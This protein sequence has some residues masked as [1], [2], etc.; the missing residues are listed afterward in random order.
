MRLGYFSSKSREPQRHS[1]I[2]LK[3]L[4]LPFGFGP[5]GQAE[6]RHSIQGPPSDPWNPCHA[7][8]NTGNGARHQECDRI[9]GF[10]QALGLYAGEIDR[11]AG[12]IAP[13]HSSYG[14]HNSKYF[15]CR[16]QDDSLGWSCSPSLF[17]IR[18]ATEFVSQTR[19]HTWPCRP[20][21]HEDRSQES[22]VSLKS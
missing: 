17:T 10:G 21:A 11:E 22:K 15:G 14:A 2:V 12:L 4:M 5:Q 18:P 20:E 1:G 8:G 19:L 13:F 9:S 6:K 16:R 7:G 3:P